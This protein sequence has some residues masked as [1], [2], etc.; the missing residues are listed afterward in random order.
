MKI[1]KILKLQLDNKYD[2][3]KHRSAKAFL[4]STFKYLAI[5]LAI[6][7]ALYLFL[8]EIFFY[9]AININAEFLAIVLVITQAI[10]FCFSVANIIKTLF[11][12]KD[13]DLI[14]VLPITFNQLFVSK[15]ILL[16][17]AELFFSILY[18]LPVFLTLGVI[19]SLGATYFVMILA[20]IP[21][22]PIIPIATA[23]LIS[24]PIMMLM[25]WFK[26]KP[27]IS[28]I[29]VFLVT[30]VLFVLYMNVVSKLSG[31]FNIAEKQIETSIKINKNVRRI[32]S[33][34]FLYYFIAQSL[35]DFKLLY[36][37]LIF[38]LMGM[39]MLVVCFVA[40]KRIYFKI[41]SITTDHKTS[42]MPKYKKF[43]KRTPFNELLLN[44]M[45]SVF[46]SPSYV[47]Q[48]FIFAL[49]MPLIVYVYDKLLIAIAVNQTGQAMIVGSHI[50]IL[51][52]AALMS[53]TI[54]STALSRE[55]GTL[56]ISKN[57]PVS[58]YAKVGS[59]IVFNTILTLGAILITTISSLIFTDLSPI[60][61]IISSI[62][63]AILAFGHIC[64]S[65]DID[66]T[67]PTLDW[68]DS[69]EIV[70]LS[71]NTT[72]CIIWALILSALLFFLT[73]LSP[74]YGIYLTLIFS[75]MY[76]LLRLYC[77]FIKLKHYYTKME[78]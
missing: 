63:V 47:F 36:Y 54:S 43:K 3:F 75:V 62:S 29:F 46:R 34:I 15:V 2:L 45:R 56:Y 38:L 71:K 49:L 30:A 26:N 76:C 33:D 7:L 68:Y 11:L 42:E 14:I 18:I 13:Y 60:V 32:G 67:N 25:K 1:A 22:L 72:K 78:L 12:N 57:T 6:T 27:L 39:A 64:H 40:V 10:V 58:Y 50:L 41:I 66:L 74:D 19:G 35:L 24:I 51:S 55:G 59:K 70:E 44:E 52:I 73:I 53:N 37:P 20:I 21:I 9:L 23:S 61:V 77:L 28:I 8:K 31:A 16:Y 65:L 5:V 69:G 17:I 4:R 48:Y